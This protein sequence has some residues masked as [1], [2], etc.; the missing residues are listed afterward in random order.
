MR[1][2]N[3][4]FENKKLELRIEQIS[5]SNLSLLVGVSGVGKTMI[6]QSLL[7]LKQI[8]KGESL[9]GAEWEIRFSIKEGENYLWKGAF[10]RNGIEEFVERALHGRGEEKTET[11]SRPIILYE[12]LHK[13]NRL[14]IERKKNEIKLE[15]KPTPKLS[16]YKSSLNLFNEEEILSP[17][18]ESFKRIVHSEDYTW[19][20]VSFREFLKEYQT[21]ES[22]RNAS[23][24]ISLKLALIYENQPDT[25]NLIKKHFINV[26]T[27]VEDIRFKSMADSPL[28]VH[29]TPFLQIR[30][31]NVPKWIFHNKISSGMLKTLIQISQLF[32]CSEG[33]VILI[34]EFENSL[35]INC[36]DILTEN[37]IDD[38]RN[39]QFI[40]TSHHPYIINAIGMEYWKV[41]S[42]RGGVISTKDAKEYKLGKS[43]HEAFKQ[44][45]QLSDYRKGIKV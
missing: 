30:E 2:D 27:Q 21:L 32:L 36:I 22:I 35:G 1:I 31:K 8:A 4:K 24:P 25:F 10:E 6:L 38:S 45:I 42:R 20:P 16:S 19:L 33:T 29:D 41:V 15:G 11:I 26:F 3:F 40:L 12:E 18:F 28:F 43:K 13:N 23:I 5:F 17:V 34:D 37:L 7:D 14:I 39:I 44:L 9:S